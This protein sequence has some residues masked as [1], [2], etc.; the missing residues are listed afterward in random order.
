MNVELANLCLLP[1]YL[2]RGGI[3]DFHCLIKNVY[4][5]FCFYACFVKTN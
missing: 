3:T 4:S 5:Q 2:V 1:Q